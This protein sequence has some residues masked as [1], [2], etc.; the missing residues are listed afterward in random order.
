MANIRNTSDNA[1]CKD[2]RWAD[3]HAL[4]RQHERNP[5]FVC[6]AINDIGK[7]EFE[8]ASIRPNEHWKYSPPPYSL[9]FHESFVGSQPLF[10]VDAPL[11]LLIAFAY[12][13]N[14]QYSVL[15]NLSQ[16]LHHNL[17]TSQL[18]SRGTDER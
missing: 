18:A 9:D 7:A 11:S 10:T 2:S 3:T 17:S 6:A 13:L 8:V 4:Q 5:S 15:T 1:A 14:S 16:W 12:K